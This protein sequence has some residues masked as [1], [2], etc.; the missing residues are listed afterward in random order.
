MIERLAP[1]PIVIDTDPGI[2]DALAIIL[3]LRSPELRVE[4]VT[5]VAGN[6]DVRAATDNARRLLALLDPDEPPRLVRG[7]ARPLRGRLKTAPT[8]HGGDGLAGLSGQ[9]DRHGRPLFPAGD[10]PKPAGGNAATAI[11]A[12]AREHGE[13]LTIAAL[14]PLTNIA[15]ALEEDAAAMRRIGRLIIMGGANRGAGKRDPPVRSSTFTSI[16]SRRTGSSRPGCALP[17]FRST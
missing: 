2:D 7:A 6:T 16:R 11:V 8:V 10:G 13:A 3:A 4:L 12:K 15:R 1:H 5:T 9:L 17:S 14:G